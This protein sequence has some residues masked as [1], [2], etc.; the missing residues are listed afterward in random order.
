MIVRQWSELLDTVMPGK[1]S[2]A[3]L[4][5]LGPIVIFS[6]SLKLCLNG[7]S[8][9]VVRAIVKFNLEGYQQ[10]HFNCTARVPL[11]RTRLF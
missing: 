9:S 6:S 4:T 11:L 7:S 1:N 2:R 5:V 3:S 8:F 10:I